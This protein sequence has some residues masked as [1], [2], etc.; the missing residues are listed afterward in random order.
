MSPCLSD[1]LMSMKRV[2][3]AICALLLVALVVQGVSASFA[4]TNLAVTAKG[5]PSGPDEKIAAGTP[6]TASATI[7]FDAEGDVTFPQANTLLLA[8]DLDNAIWTYYRILDSVQDP[9]PTK[10]KGK[11][12]N[13][14]GWM[15]SYPSRQ[16]L[17]ITAKVEGTA[18][19]VSVSG[20][21]VIFRVAELNSRGNPIQGGEVITKRFIINP[22]EITGVVGSARS[23]LAALRSAIDV[24]V[25]LGANTDEAEAAYRDAKEALD[26]AD[27]ATTDGK[28]TD[29]QTYS[30][31]AGVLIKNGM[32]LLDKGI[33]QKSVD[34]AQH[35][36]DTSD[37]IITYFKVNRSMG[38]DLRVVSLITTRDEAANLI[39]DANDLLSQKNYSNAK[40]K[41]GQAE[42][43]A[44]QTLE[45]AMAL[46]KE[47][48][49][50]LPGMPSVGLPSIDTSGVGGFLAGSLTYILGVIGV[51]IIVVIGVVLYRR[52]SG[53]D[54]LG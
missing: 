2:V 25:A 37:E 11:N 44:N 32:T 5:A 14:I 50:A 54:E 34:D 35:N 42:D 26:K 51:V 39:S 40:D 17:S 7:E 12:V 49:E 21:Q 36:L 48:G 10:I 24:Q 45:N 4:V 43:K 38:S 41:A 22:S 18:P 9:T 27:K 15:L 13:I 16:E 31:N 47:V 28:Y 8:T 46:R 1:V 3:S 53:W 19:A 20:D 30:A 23:D 33:A 6:M 52:R 29:A